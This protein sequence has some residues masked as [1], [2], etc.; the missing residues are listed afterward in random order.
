MGLQE[1]LKALPDKIRQYRDEARV[2]LHLARQDVKDEFDNLEQEWDR[3]KGKCD[4]TL[5]DATEVSTEAL[6]TV[7]IMGEDLKKGYQN[8]RDKIK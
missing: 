8:I 6:L 3:F 1:E 4:H 7:Q 5:D 2:Q